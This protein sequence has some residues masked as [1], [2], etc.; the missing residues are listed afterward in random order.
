MNPHVQSAD[1]V[2]ALDACGVVAILRGD[3]L[4]RIDEVVET[5]VEGGIKAIEISLSAS[6]AYAQIERA[7]ARA[8]SAVALGAGTVMTCD[9]VHAV[10]DRGVSF[11]VAPIVDP[12]VLACAHE[13]GLASLPGAYTPTEAVTAARLGATAIKLFPAETLGPAFVRG[14]L[15]PLPA[16]KL[17]PTGGVTLERARAFAAAGAWAVGV[18]SPLIASLADL[19]DPGA[20]RA[21]ARAF[22]DAMRPS[23]SAS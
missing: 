10:R 13:L 20:L 5:L 23:T 18:G 11:I 3:F 2:A 17:V 1:L 6:T 21:R 7:V 12:D 4:A 15:A 8:G 9:Q 14:L 19:N 16:L 22:V